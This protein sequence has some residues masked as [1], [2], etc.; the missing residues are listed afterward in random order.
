MYIPIKGN[1]AEVPGLLRIIVRGQAVYDD[2]LRA[3]RIPGRAQSKYRKAG[4]D[5]RTERG[6]SIPYGVGALS[7]ESSEIRKLAFGGYLHT[8]IPFRKIPTV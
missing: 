6:P 1:P 3:V 8:P 4:A 5:G 7:K 2:E